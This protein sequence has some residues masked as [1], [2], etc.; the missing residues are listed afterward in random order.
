MIREIGSG[1]GLI[2]GWEVANAVAARDHAAALAEARRLIDSGEEP[3]RIVGGLAW[4]ARVML[5]AK[6]MLEAGVRAD[7]VYGTLPT[8]GWKKELLRG[9]RAYSLDELLAFPARLLAADRAL[10]SRSLGK[11]AVLENLVDELT[12]GADGGSL[13]Q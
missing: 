3:L 6:S 1:G 13:N 4:R 9:M 5:Q 8:W 12:G 11:R 7:E 10:K 2:A